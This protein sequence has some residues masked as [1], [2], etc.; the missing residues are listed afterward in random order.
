MRTTRRASRTTP[1]RTLLPIAALVAG[2]GLATA[3]YVTAKLRHGRPLHPR[4]RSFDAT[5]VMDGG[6][7]TGVRW[8]DEARVDEATVR[9]SRAIGLPERWP[10]IYG[11]ALR[12]RGPDGSTADVLLASTGGGRLGR[13]TL[14]LRSGVEAGP[15]TTLLPLKAPVGPLLFRV[16]TPG[17]TPVNEGD[18]PHTMVISYAVGLGPWVEAGQLRAGPRRSPAKDAERH[19][20]VVQQLPGTEQ[21][22]VVRRLREP[23]YRAARRQRPRM[24]GAA[25]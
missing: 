7:S 1:T 11:L 21:Y 4:G 13:M 18:L 17:R 5:V 12:L 8:L 20:P 10:D 15:L 3:A 2:R 22:E 23:A 16:H 25:R 24:P 6:H 9:V 14:R 19:D